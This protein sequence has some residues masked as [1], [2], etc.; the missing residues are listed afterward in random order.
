M[1]FS[2]SLEYVL[3]Q[4]PKNYQVNKRFPLTKNMLDFLLV[5]LQGLGKTL[6]RVLETCKVISELTLQRFRL[7]HFWKIAA[8]IY[9]ITARIFVISKNIFKFV[10]ELY[11]NLL[12]FSSSLNNAGGQ[13]LPDGYVFPP[14]LDQ[15]LELDWLNLEDNVIEIPD[16]EPDSSFFKFLGDSDDEVEFCDEY[17]LVGDDS[18]I[19][20][21]DI[22]MCENQDTKDILLFDQSQEPNMEDLVI[23]CDN[24]KVKKPKRNK[25]E[26]TDTN[27]N[28]NEEID[29]GELV[30][31]C[32]NTENAMKNRKRKR[33]NDRR[34]FKG[35]LGHNKH[36]EVQHHARKK[37]KKKSQKRQR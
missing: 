8:I 37:P 32:D 10:C 13:W 25:W 20:D 4:I 30:I 36:T 3:Q 7:G 12:P 2:K 28:S 6:C 15:W 23:V 21:S 18:T 19:Q 11:L 22:E 33:L 34:N 27:L 24:T 16:D 14:R 35:N 17:V 1:N 26:I 9:A 5:R 31:V 29:V